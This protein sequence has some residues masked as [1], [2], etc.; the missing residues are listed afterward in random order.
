MLVDFRADFADV[1]PSATTALSSSNYYAHK[2]KKEFK[3]NDFYSNPENYIST[4][5]KFIPQTDILINGTYWNPNSPRLFEE[6]Q[7]NKNFKI[8]V[9]GDITCDINGSI[10]CTKFAS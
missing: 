5:K 3:R 10:P 6:N 9:I 4:F 1:S 8:K 2:N 7:M